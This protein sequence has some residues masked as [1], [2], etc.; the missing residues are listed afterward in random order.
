M[1]IID[2]TD[3]DKDRKEAP[4]GGELLATYQDP[5]DPNSELV[6]VYVSHKKEWWVWTY[7]KDRG[8]EHGRWFKDRRS[9]LSLFQEKQLSME[10]ATKKPAHAGKPQ[11]HLIKVPYISDEEAEEASGSV[12]A[13][14]EHYGIRDE[15]HKDLL[16][17]GMI[18]VFVRSKL[19]MGDN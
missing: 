11:D 10:P 6:L 5:S 7:Y 13:V 17:N 18:T 12:D 9:A 16:Y 1:E 15:N 14:L 8:Y 3:K 2:L 19:L 4:H